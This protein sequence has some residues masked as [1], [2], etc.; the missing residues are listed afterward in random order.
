MA[1]AERLLE[2]RALAC[3]GRRVGEL[4]GEQLLV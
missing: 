2:R 3:C 1:V 4:L